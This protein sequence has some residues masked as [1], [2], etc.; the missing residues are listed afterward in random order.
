MNKNNNTNNAPR[1][2]DGSLAKIAKGGLPLSGSE[3]PFT[4]SVYGSEKWGKRNNNCYG[5]ALDWFKAS[6]NRKLQPGELSKTLKP[7]DDLTDPAVL[8]KRS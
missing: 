2:S 3:E 7:Y 5:F 6:E 4:N 8:K 1:S